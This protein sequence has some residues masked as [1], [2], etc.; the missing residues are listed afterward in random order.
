MAI[1]GYNEVE[2]TWNLFHRV[3]RPK[4]IHFYGSYDEIR[5]FFIFHQFRAVLGPLGPIPGKPDFSGKIRLCN[6]SSNII[7]KLLA[8]FQKHPTSRFPE[9]WKLL[10]LPPYLLTIIWAVGSTDVE[11]CSVP[12]MAL[13]S[14]SEIILRTFELL[15]YSSFSSFHIQ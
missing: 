2:M 15:F 12:H 1:F 9:L 13:G 3:S 14:T 10:T 5:W 8:G 7:P 11:N 4:A 6:F